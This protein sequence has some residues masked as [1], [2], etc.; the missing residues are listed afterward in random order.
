MR[1]RG[2]GKAPKQSNMKNRNNF[3]RNKTFRDFWTQASKVL[4][5]NSEYEHGEDGKIVKGKAPNLKKVR[6]FYKK[7][8]KHRRMHGKRK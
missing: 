6:N 4:S 3:A 1:Y 2:F 5:E 8:D 7:V